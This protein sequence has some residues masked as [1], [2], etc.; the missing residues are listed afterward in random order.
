MSL[1]RVSGLAISLCGVEVFP[2]AANAA[3]AKKTTASGGNGEP[4]APRLV[5]L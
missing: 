2:Q 4:A 1:T 5:A 3:I